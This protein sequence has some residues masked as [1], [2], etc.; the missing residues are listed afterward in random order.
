MRI[1]ASACWRTHLV[2]DSRRISPA[3]LKVSPHHRIAWLHSLLPYCPESLE[4]L[5]DECPRCRKRLGWRRGWGIDT[6]EHCRTIIE[7]P[8]AEYLPD[9]LAGSYRG[10]AAI[11]AGISEKLKPVLAALAD[12]LR[13]LSPLS[14]VLLTVE[15]GRLLGDDEDDGRG[16][17]RR[18]GTLRTAEAGARGFE[19]LHEW[20]QRLRDEIATRMAILMEAGAG[21]HRRFLAA[22]RR[23]GDE[24]G[25]ARDRVDLIRRA[26]PEVFQHASRAYRIERDVIG[27]A[28]F[29]R[30]TGL[31]SAQLKLLR[32][33]GS[34]LDYAILRS[35]ERES[36]QYS[37]EHAE[38]LNACLRNSEPASR[39]A[40]RLGVPHYAVEQ[41]ACLGDVTMEADPRLKSVRPEL[42]LTSA[43]V[44][45][46]MARLVDAVSD[47]DA[48]DGAIPVSRAV[49]VIGGRCKPWGAI[50]EAL[51][52]GEV[53]AWWP[54]GTDTGSLPKIALFRT[55]L[56]M[57]HAF[58]SLRDVAFDQAA[59]SGF[60]F[61]REIS[62]RDA[63]EIL[64]LD[65]VLIRPAVSAG[66]LNA[67][68]GAARG[69]EFELA[70][71]LDLA[72]EIVS[73]AELAPVLGVRENNVRGWL[74]KHRPEISEETVGWSRRAFANA[75]NEL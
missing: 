34:A 17:V 66:R 72:A 51:A 9:A 27:T 6:C 49:R 36:A 20:P 63:C 21:G 11:A 4:L 30:L 69:Q 24:D 39:L 28:E 58:V 46:L 70:E 71:I 40:G 41:L 45:A 31:S 37:R 23:L 26:L 5:I 64:N 35:G 73:A 74:L 54:A 3:S 12:E 14:L 1:G 42:R 67:R 16:D 57:P 55:M 15:L 47:A 32:D 52:A 7:S 48:P 22:L 60:A 29:S 19:L 50:F 65:N 38:D 18:L 13:A 62:Q 68:K 33:D 25:R 8:D 56:V 61:A 43:S 2:F 53:A 75:R 44:E 10:F 59:W